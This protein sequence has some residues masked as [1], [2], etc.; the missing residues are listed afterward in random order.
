M[1]QG[2]SRSVMAQRFI[3]EIAEGDHRVLLIDGKP[4]PHCLARIPKAGESRG[5]L[6][7]GARGV[8]KPLSKRQREIGEALGPVLA[9]RGLLLVGLDIIGDWLT[10]VNVTSPTCFREI[11]DQTGFDVPG[12][13]MDALELR[14]Q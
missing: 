2:G 4:V 7:A 6:A 3:P 8:A 1:A 5:N 12:M 13:F 9:K 14:L 11:A 10:E